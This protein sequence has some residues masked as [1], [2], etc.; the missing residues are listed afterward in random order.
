MQFLTKTLNERPATRA[1]VRQLADHYL[2]GLKYAVSGSVDFEKYT[3]VTQDYLLRTWYG[4]D[5]KQGTADDTK[6]KMT[7][8]NAFVGRY[9]H[10]II[11]SF[12]RKSANFMGFYYEDECRKAGIEEAYFRQSDNL[13]KRPG[14]GDIVKFKRHHVAVAL[15]SKGGFWNRIE[16]GQGGRSAGA[17]VIVFRENQPY[18]PGEIEGWVNLAILFDYNSLIAERQRDTKS[19]N[20]SP[21][22]SLMQA[23]RTAHRNRL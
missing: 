10:S 15:A 16:S 12:Q 17:D 2:N 7:T 4:P 14:Y 9:A 19:W 3:G 18:H 20:D 23:N 8:C 6:S 21:W 1:R 5:K 11:P 22:Q 13:D